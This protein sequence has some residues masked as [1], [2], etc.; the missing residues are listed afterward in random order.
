VE[1]VVGDDQPEHRVAE[2][3]EP[4]VGVV[5]RVLRAPRPV[6]ERGGEH[7]GGVEYDAEAQGQLIETWDGKWDDRAF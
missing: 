1:G 7:L 4:L 2:E 5:A 6:D 3:L